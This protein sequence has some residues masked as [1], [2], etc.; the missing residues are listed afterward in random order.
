M[1]KVNKYSTHKF[2]Q[3]NITFLLSYS[4]KMQKSYKILFF[5]FPSP[6]LVFKPW[7]G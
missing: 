3:K 5:S 4:K 1:V 6:L 2:T 7:A